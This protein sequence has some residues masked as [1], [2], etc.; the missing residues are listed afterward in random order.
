MNFPILDSVS[1][2]LSAAIVTPAERIA[3]G[4]LIGALSGLGVGIVLV[5]L[6]GAVQRTRKRKGDLWV[7][8][9]AV[10][11]PVIGMLFGQYI[12]SRT[13]QGEMGQ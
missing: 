8:S 2:Q 9:T 5:S 1:K 10:T 11:A 13:A 6:T 12:A 4:S 7:W 3:Q